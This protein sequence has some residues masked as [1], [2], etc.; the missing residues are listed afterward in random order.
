MGQVVQFFW[1]F[2]CVPPQVE[3]G[4]CKRHAHL[5][6]SCKEG[7]C[8]AIVEDLRPLNSRH[9]RISAW[10]PW[11]LS[12][13]IGMHTHTHIYIY[14]YI[15]LCN[16]YIYI[17]VCVCVRVCVFMYIYILY[18]FNTYQ[19]ILYCSIKTAYMYKKIYIQFYIL[20]RFICPSSSI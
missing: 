20:Y 8:K 3:D 18:L 4:L 13:R 14:I 16:I 1:T 9:P 11:I 2:G 10:L 19:Y 15:H 5:P 12:I 17:Y 7:D 6:A